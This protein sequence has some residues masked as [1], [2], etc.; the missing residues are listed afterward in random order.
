MY[1]QMTKDEV[2]KIMINNNQQATVLDAT[3]E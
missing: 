2:K 3:G 1:A